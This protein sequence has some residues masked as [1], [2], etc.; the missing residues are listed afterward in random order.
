MLLPLQRR[1]EYIS[2][3][4]YR[5]LVKPLLFRFDPEAVHN[6]I[7]NTGEKLGEYR[8][9]RKFISAVYG[10]REQDIS[11]TV[12]GITYKTPV[13]LSAGFDYN[14]R[15]T[16][17]L[18]YVSFGGVEVGSITARKCVGNN[19]PQLTRLPLSKSLIVNKGLRNDGVE[20][21][22]Q[23][24]KEKPR[25]PDF[26]IGA[27]I[28]RTNDKVA[29]SVEAGIEDYVTSFR[30]L[31][32]T[33]I[34]DYYTI[35]I[36]CPN[37]YGGETFATPALLT[38]LMDALG[39]I[40]CAKPVY[41]K[42]PISLEWAEF[43][44]LLRVLDKSRINGVITGNLS[45]DYSTIHPREVRSEFGGGLSGK[46]CEKVS[47]ELI[48]KTKEKYKNR[49]TIIG[50]GGIFSPEDAMAKFRAGA[51]LVMLITGMI[52]EGPAL[53]KAICEKYSEEINRKA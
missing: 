16:R 19:A 2:L 1:L 13:L 44:A 8:A 4:V 11:K 28:A 30:K 52:Y 29:S 18:P 48:K 15:L 35:N 14:G 41:V 3:M 27:S 17:I 9:G 25:E 46:P 51:D 45:K 36:S 37:A 5:Y 31:N 24:L 47:T 53:I 50:C 26:V 39:A 33:G 7:T 34:G 6:F 49:F 10:Y 22:I 38:R 12:D 43:D 21:I 32:A 23:R 20:K 42:M 40:P